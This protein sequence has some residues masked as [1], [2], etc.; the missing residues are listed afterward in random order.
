MKV[1]GNKRERVTTRIE[2]SRLRHEKGGR[3]DEGNK[4]N[5][6]TKPR[7]ALSSNGVLRSEASWFRREVAG[8]G[9]RREVRGEQQSFDSRVSDNRIRGCEDTRGEFGTKEEGGSVGRGMFDGV[10]TARESS[11]IRAASRTTEEN[12]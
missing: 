6:S 7:G 10:S 8:L 12:N 1:S 4:R 3:E 11:Y 9:I 5:L 2:R